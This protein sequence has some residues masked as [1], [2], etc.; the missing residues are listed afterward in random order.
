VTPAEPF[1]PRLRPLSVGEMLDVSIKICVAHWRTLLK[2]VL[3]VVVP[4]QI[5]ST[6]L[7]ADYT[8]SQFDLTT[9]PNQ[10]PQETLDE[11]NQYI[12]GLTITTLLQIGAVLLASAAC[13]RAVAQAYLGEQTDWRGSLAFALRRAP[14]L[15]W[16]TL[17]YSFGVL[18]GTVL[19]IAPGVWLFIAWAFALPALL[20]EGVRG[21][22]AL[23]RSYRLVKGRWW[24]T[25]GVVALGFVLAGITSS[26]V[27]ALFVAGIFFNSGNDALVLA[28]SA[29]AG[30]VGLLITTPFQSALLAV[31]YFDLRV[32]KEGFDLEL[33]AAGIGGAATP[34]P[35]DPDELWPQRAE[36]SASALWPQPRAAGEG[37]GPDVPDER[38]RAAGEGGGPDA[39]DDRDD[40]EPPRLPGV[41]F[42]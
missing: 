24:R 20:A 17:L 22:R 6:L 41:P 4:M 40:D 16:L 9:S 2:T 34:L 18:F 39:P 37:G 7:T 14:S 38:S 25:F 8:V 33:L 26:V 36:P 28:L 19:L 10:T 5:L 11:L 42:G 13:F 12:G 31:V 30:V 21:R 1:R 35:E 15:L 29:I 27:Q 23:G 32:R 3:V